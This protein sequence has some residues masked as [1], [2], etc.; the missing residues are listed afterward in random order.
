MNTLEDKKNGGPEEAHTKE[1]TIIVNGRKVSII[2][3]DISYSMLVELSQTPTGENV[4]H[5]IT[6]RNGHGNKPM[7]SLVEGESIKVKD[8]MIF[9]V[10]ATDRS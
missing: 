1:I 3:Q 6:Y 5:T 7:G 10:T 9:N 8:E 2:K 4:T